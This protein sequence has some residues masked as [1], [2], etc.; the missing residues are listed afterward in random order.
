[1]NKFQKLA[2]LNKD[3]E[4]LE[5]YGK[6]KSASILHDKFIRVAQKVYPSNSST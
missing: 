2:E 5:A 6:I 3:I 1:M 4:L